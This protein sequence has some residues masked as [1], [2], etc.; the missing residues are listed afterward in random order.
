MAGTTKTES[1]AV[2]VTGGSKGIG[3]A[4]AKRLA[5]S[6]FDIWLNY[7]TSHEHAERVRDEIVSMGRE[8]L[9]LPFDV[10]DTSASAQALS[11]LA[12]R[13]APFGI[14]H[15]AGITRDSLAAM[16][17]PEEWN[18]V[19]G[20]HLNGFYNVV[21]PLL[22]F[23]MRARRGRI[24]A[25][26]SV[27]GQTGQAG[28]FNYSAAKGGLIGGAKALAREVAARNILVNCVSP[29]LIE[30]DMSSDVPID[31]ILPMIPMNRPGSADEIAGVVNFLFSSDAS[32]ITGQVIGVNG[33]LYI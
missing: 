30:T 9:L 10:A 20:V 25:V 28:Q 15:N 1:G 23:M 19:I 8:C 3:A 13:Q 31:K 11:P 14:V 32:Y 6:G 4:I 29:G 21:H 18:L 22:R 24:V 2:L 7:H 16:M 17:S 5:V 33:G 27:S 26:T 12:E